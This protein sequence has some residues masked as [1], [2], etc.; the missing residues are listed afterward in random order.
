MIEDEEPVKEIMN[1][2]GDEMKKVKVQ[3]HEVIVMVSSA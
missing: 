1:T 3:E 2:V